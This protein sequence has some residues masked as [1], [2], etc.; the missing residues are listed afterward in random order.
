MR[1]LRVGIVGLGGIA[2]KVYLPIL[3]QAKHWELVGAYTPNQQKNCLLCQQYRIVSFFSLDELA[4]NC[5]VAFVHSATAAHY[6][7][8][9]HLLRK[10]LHVYID[11]PLA[12]TLDQ[13]EALAE[14]AN[15]E[16]RALMVGF[17]RRFAPF[18]QTIKAQ[19]PCVSS[20]RFEKHRIH[21]IGNTLRFTLFD[22]YLH[23]L[24]TVLWLCDGELSLL[25]SQV[26]ATVLDELVF[27]SHVFRHDSKLITTAMHRDAGT[28]AETLEVI[29]HGAVMRVRDLNRLEEERDG[30]IHVSIAG[31]W[32]T[33][34]EL[35]GFVPMVEHFLECVANQTTPL[36]SGEQALMA[37]RWMEKL[38]ADRAQ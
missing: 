22:D 35:R 37:Q 30:K 32:Q 12:D 5:D 15:K 18:Y 7:I 9:D 4:A 20:V 28:Q 6:E 36:V 38:L 14:L 11:K 24:D 1:K 26:N 21:G 2:Q 8:A 3:S 34:L 23:L 13:A 17:N 31:S 25:A 10:G 16:Q 33:I 19:M 27:A 29:T